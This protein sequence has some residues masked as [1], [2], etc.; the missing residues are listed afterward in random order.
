MALRKRLTSFLT[1]KSWIASMKKYSGIVKV[2]I[3]KTF[4]TS[5][6]CSEAHSALNQTLIQRY[7][8]YGPSIWNITIRWLIT[9]H[10]FALP[11]VI[12][13]IC[14]TRAQ[15]IQSSNRVITVDACFS[16]R[17]GLYGAASSISPIHAISRETL[18]ASRRFFSEKDYWT[19]FRLARSLQRFGVIN[20]RL[21]TG[22]ALRFM[23]RSYFCLFTRP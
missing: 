19:G 9:K 7:N 5:L 10:L 21:R 14:P 8:H 2:D 6:R 20:K 23:Q 1:L 17:N 18:Q 15:T 3:L 4:S 13:A 12:F 16:R 22:I 11:A